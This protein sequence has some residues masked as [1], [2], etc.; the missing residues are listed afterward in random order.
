MTVVGVVADTKSNG[1][2]QPVDPTMYTPIFQK[3]EEW[4]RW[5]TIVVRSAGPPPMQ[6]A[7][8]VKRQVWNSDAQIPLVQVQPMSSYLEES[9]AERRFNTSLLGVLAAV[10]LTLA[11]I[12]VYGVISYTVERRTREFGIR[13]ALGAITS[14]LLRIVLAGA[15]RIIAIGAAIGLAAAMLIT[16]LISGMLFGVSSRD[17]LTFVATALLLAAVGLFAAFVPARRASRVDPL[18]ALRYE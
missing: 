4:R 9:L 10:S 7:S 3:Q 18:V 13:M 8:I 11:M 14:D 17:P 16:R 2:D 5:A 12:G 6:L 15:F 1:L